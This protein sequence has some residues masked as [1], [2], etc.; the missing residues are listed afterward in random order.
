MWSP[1]CPSSGQEQII[2]GFALWL[3]QEIR[4]GCP[5]CS[6]LHPPSCLFWRWTYYLFAPS[7]SRADSILSWLSLCCISLYPGSLWILYVSKCMLNFC[8]SWV[9]RLVTHCE[10]L[11]TD[12]P[13]WT[14]RSLERSWPWPHFSLDPANHRGSK[15]EFVMP[16]KLSPGSGTAQLQVTTH[17]LGFCEA[18]VSS[19]SLSLFIPPSPF[20]FCYF[21]PQ[22]N[23]IMFPDSVLFDK[24]AWK[25]GIRRSGVCCSN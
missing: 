8:A 1:S 13:T 21:I 22:I 10:T 5:S 12:S 14:G 19:V 15:K 2:W 3:P 24:P 25:L 9:L 11:L 7:I 17:I 18:S 20:S 6:S 23:E 16:M 4:W